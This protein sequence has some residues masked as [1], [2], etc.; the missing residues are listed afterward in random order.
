MGETMKK[1][2][3]RKI[4]QALATLAVLGLLTSACGGGAS[5]SEE[6]TDAPAESEVAALTGEPIKVMTVT[7]INASGQTYQN[8]ADTAKAYEQYINAR[9]GIAG[10]PLE[11]TVCDEQFDPAIAT[12]CARKA[13][14]EG[15]VSIIGSFTYF[16]E[17][18]IPV[19]AESNIT[20]FGCVL[21]NCAI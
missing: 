21:C 20:W 7:T 15:M 19:I 13:V 18:I 6:G 2:F 4:G 11:V 14:E 1:G 9:G 8:I 16:G 5:T 3:N 10:R 17:S 12:T